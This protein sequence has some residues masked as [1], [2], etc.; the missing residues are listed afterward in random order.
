MRDAQ[1][2]V[3]PDVALLERA[4]VGA[5]E[6]ELGRVG[7][8]L[9]LDVAVAQVDAPLAQR[10]HLGADEDDARLVGVVDE[11]VVARLAVLG[12]AFDAGLSCHG[13]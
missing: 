13:H 10:L 6:E 3:V 12:H 2:F 4:D 11:V 7:G 8:A 9:D 5:D 1:R